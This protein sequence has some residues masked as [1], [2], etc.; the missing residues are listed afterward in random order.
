LANRLRCEYHLRESSKFESMFAS[1]VTLLPHQLP[2]T[3][4]IFGGVLGMSASRQ[5][6]PL[7]GSKSN[8][9]FTPESRLNSEI[10]ACPKSAKLGPNVEGA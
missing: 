1:A 4:N 3:I 9:R 2:R 7:A 6:L 8:F 5:K 10:A